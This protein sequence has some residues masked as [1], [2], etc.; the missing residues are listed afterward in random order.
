[1]MTG[2]ELRYEPDPRAWLVGPTGERF[3]EAWVDG[4][5]ATLVRDFEVADD[6]TRAY[7]RRVLERVAVDESSQLTERLLRWR[8][9]GEAPFVVFLGMVDRD[10][11]SD[12]DLEAYLQS[13]GEGLVEPAVV[14]DVE[15][16]DGLSVRRSIGYSSHPEGVVAGVRYVVDVGAASAVGVLHTATRVPGQLIEA[17]DDLDDLAR[18]VR[19]L[20][21]AT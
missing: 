13:E 6:Q 15:A 7:V 3:G 10:E 19:V 4:A 16:P 17:L 2:P 5:L 9:V 1:M 11:W 12:D 8:A 21:P 20:D 18:T 14:T